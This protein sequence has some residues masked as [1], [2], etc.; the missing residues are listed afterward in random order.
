[1]ERIAVPQREKKNDEND[2][3]IGD[4]NDIDIGHKPY[5]PQPYQG[6][7]SCPTLLKC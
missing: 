4:E 3:D 2:I 7:D 6:I 1:V 5:R